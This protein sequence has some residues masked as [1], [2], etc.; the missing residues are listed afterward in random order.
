MFSFPSQRKP[1]KVDVIEESLKV[2]LEAKHIIKFKSLLR[3]KQKKPKIKKKNNDDDEKM[4]LLVGILSVVA[5][6]VVSGWF[7]YKG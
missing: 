6:P 5:V 7:E 4:M 2:C 3:L 1:F